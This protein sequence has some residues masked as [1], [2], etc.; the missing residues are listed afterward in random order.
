MEVCCP[1]NDDDDGYGDDDDAQCELEH[2]DDFTT[3]KL[4]VFCKLYDSLPTP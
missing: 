4:K 2:Y 1:F 3:G